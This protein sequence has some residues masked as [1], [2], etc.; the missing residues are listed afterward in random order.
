MLSD[1]ALN[2]AMCLSGH[3]AAPLQQLSIWFCITSYSSYV[4]QTSMS[5]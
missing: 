4:K 3:T 2:L 5:L 1:F